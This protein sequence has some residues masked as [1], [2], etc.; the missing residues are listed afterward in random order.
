MIRVSLFVYFM[1]QCIGTFAQVGSNSNFYFSE[2]PV[3]PIATG[4][5]VIAVGAY[6]T[7]LNQ[8]V[9][10][11]AFIDST[12]DQSIALSY[13]NYLSDI[14]QV[15]L[16]YGQLVDGV[17]LVSGYLRY[18]D[19]GTFQETDEFGQELGEF[20]SS[21]YELGITLGK[22]YSDKISYGVTVK[23]L[24]SNLYKQFA[25][26]IAADIGGYYSTEK[27]LSFGVT[28]DNVGM[29][30][31]DYSGTSFSWMK[32]SV[33]LGISKK[34]SKA[35]LQIGLQ[36][37]NIET[38]DLAVNDIDQA[39]NLTVDQLTGESSRR[40]FTFDNLARHLNISVAFIPSKK[41][42]IFGGFNAR[43]RLE[44][45]ANQRPA[46]IGFSLGTQIRVSRFNFQYALSSYHLNGAVNHLGITTNLHDWYSKK[47]L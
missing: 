3:S 13:Q 30:M 14:N 36:Y 11:P 24:F 6:D 32:P 42:N 44:L 21:D 12:L 4:L 39:N 18:L 5:G 23:Q 7:D 35:P 33:N 26:G 28:L 34:F 9:S 8:V 40:T 43:R 19:Y 29:R 45:A 1:L 47:A 10:N 31:V 46:L 20:S 25:Y 16:S 41:I 17:G 37:N 38:W 15:S 22:T 2:M 27:G